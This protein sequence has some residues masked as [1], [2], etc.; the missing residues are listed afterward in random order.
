MQ[1]DKPNRIELEP[2]RPQREPRLTTVVL[3]DEEIFCPICN[4]NLTGND[5][6]RCPECGS[7]FDRHALIAAQRADAV[8]LIPWDDPEE[9]PFLKRFR[10]TLKICL[11]NAERFAFAFSVQ[12]QESKALSFFAMVTA[13]TIV[14]GW[15]TCAVYLLSANPF[16][17]GVSR[18]LTGV[19]CCVVVCMHVVLSLLVGTLLS[20]VTLWIFCPHYDG[21]RHLKPWLSIAAYASAHY[22]MFATAIPIAALV[23]LVIGRPDSFEDIT[24]V[25]LIWLGCATLCVL[26]LRAVVFFRMAEIEDYRF[27]IFLLAAIHVGSSLVS[28]YLSVS[29]GQWIA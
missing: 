23:P 11:V 1:H 8:T 10:E 25:T 16:T 27:T 12:P 28:L 18:L 13:T 2:L 29:V 17:A 4:Y 7:F 26:T 24:V 20:G 6:G 9:M 3:E 22:L 14:F 15:M 5:S 19:I 21:K